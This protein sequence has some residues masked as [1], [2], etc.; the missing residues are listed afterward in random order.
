MT[1]AK[2]DCSKLTTANQ[3]EE[4]AA[5]LWKIVAAKEISVDAAAEAVLAELDGIFTVNETEKPQTEPT[6]WRAENETVYVE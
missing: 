6:W 5:K 3:R 4:A 1:K 2:S